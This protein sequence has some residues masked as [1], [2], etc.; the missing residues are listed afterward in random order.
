MLRENTTR[1]MPA[2]LS[3][4]ASLLWGTA[5]FLGGEATHRRSAAAVTF[6]TQLIAAIALLL[7][8]SVLRRW[9][10]AGT[11]LLWGVGAGLVGPV[12]LACF[13]RALADGTMGVVAPIAA[14]G[15]LVPV[16]VGLATGEH[17]SAL[18]LAGVAAAFVGVLLVSGP[19]LRGVG[20]RRRS[21]FLAVA[22]AAAFGV[23]YV[24][25]A[26]GSES[27]VA[28]TLMS[29]RCVGASIMVIPALVGGG[30]RGIGG[31]ELARFTAIGLFD[32]GANGSFAV[33]STLGLLSLTA[34]LGSLYP[35]VTA[36]LARIV[37]K[38]RLRPVQLAGA[39]VVIAG[40]VLITV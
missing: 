23:V 11:G 10:D 36:V 25:L 22:A 16:A 28:M 24:C 31:R 38:E 21:V 29:M 13:Y 33:A 1:L 26:R 19:E 30:L 3:L 32:V 39:L 18:Q 14:T 20:V 34:T 12:G 9:Q 4:S 35:L 8:V 7:V 17:P 37:L 5:D 15:V 40:I 6:A 2:L 27:S